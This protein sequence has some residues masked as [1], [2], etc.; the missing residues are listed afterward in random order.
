MELQQRV[1]LGR[2]VPDVQRGQA[3]VA[4][5]HP[6][7]GRHH[8]GQ[9]PL[10]REGPLESGGGREAQEQRPQHP[11]RLEVRAV[12]LHRH[13]GR[14]RHHGVLPGELRP[15]PHAL[16]APHQRQAVRRRAPHRALQAE[17]RERAGHHVPAGDRHPLRSHRR[18]QHLP[19]PALRG[20]VPAAPPAQGRRDHAEIPHRPHALLRVFAGRPVLQVRREP[21]DAEL[22]GGPQVVRLRDP[23]EDE[24]QTVGRVQDHLHEPGGQPPPPAPVRPAHPQGLVQGGRAHL[25][26][27]L[28][29]P[30][31]REEPDVPQR[32]HGPHPHHRHGPARN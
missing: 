27:V 20:R 18:E 15:P 10:H 1:V 16:R 24:L 6:L 5:Q 30:P 11:V 22:H 29:E 4:H 28:P 17:R 31:H 25:L 14:R 32:V 19:G 12:R 21:D 26:G 8:G 7:G 3:A 2:R 23:A 9:R 13:G